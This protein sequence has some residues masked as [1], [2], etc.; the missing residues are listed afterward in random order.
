MR[1]DKGISV[2][3]LLDALANAHV[4]AYKRRPDADEEPSSPSTRIG[5]DPRL[6]PG[7]GRGRHVVREWTHSER[8]RRRRPDRQQVIPSGLASRRDM[9]YEE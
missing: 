8:L 1:C 3:T 6:R 4:A 9:K 5:R 7:T 2:E